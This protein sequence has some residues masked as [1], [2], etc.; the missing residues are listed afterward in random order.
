MLASLLPDGLCNPSV[1][2]AFGLNIQDGFAKP[3]MLKF[4]LHPEYQ[5][6]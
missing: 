3:V 6:P 2:F 5:S 4:L 1:L